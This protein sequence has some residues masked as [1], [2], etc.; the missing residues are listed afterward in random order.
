MQV[1]H[2]IG[3]GWLQGRPCGSLILFTPTEGETWFLRIML[4]LGKTICSVKAPK[5]LV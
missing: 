5:D 1:F 2:K 3:E 4:S